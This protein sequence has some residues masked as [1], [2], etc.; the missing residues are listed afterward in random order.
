MNIEAEPR[1]YHG[2]ITN[3]MTAQMKKPFRIVRYLGKRPAMSFP[4]GR[5]FSKIEE[6]IAE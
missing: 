3:E 2:L 4:A 6:K 1:R 5:E